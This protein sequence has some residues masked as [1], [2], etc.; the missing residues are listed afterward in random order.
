MTLSAC[1]KEILSVVWSKRCSSFAFLPLKCCVLLTW[2]ILLPTHTCTSVEFSRIY[3]YSALPRPGEGR[4]TGWFWS[5][6]CRWYKYIYILIKKNFCKHT[7]KEPGLA[8]STSAD[9]AETGLTHMSVYSNNVRSVGESR[10]PTEI[11]SASPISWLLLL[12]GRTVTWES[13]NC[14]DGAVGTGHSFQV[15]SQAGWAG[16]R[17]VRRRQ[18]PLGARDQLQA[19]GWGVKSRCLRD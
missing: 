1:N 18:A 8:V 10:S 2:K 15:T 13:R 17:G 3:M 6:K 5:D 19:I 16:G 4:L 7:T 14:R 9:S 11:C 12:G